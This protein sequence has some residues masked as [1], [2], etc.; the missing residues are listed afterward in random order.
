MTVKRRAAAGVLA[1]NAPKPTNAI[2][3]SQFRRIAKENSE[4]AEA[5]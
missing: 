5:R 4:P 3:R 2:N 1:R